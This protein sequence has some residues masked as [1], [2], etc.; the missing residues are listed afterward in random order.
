[1]RA[2]RV[3]DA[4]TVGAAARNVIERGSAVITA[5]LRAQMHSR[6]DERAASQSEH[7]SPSVTFERGLA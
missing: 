5:E 7:A 6:R 2:R 1:M 3:N 4:V